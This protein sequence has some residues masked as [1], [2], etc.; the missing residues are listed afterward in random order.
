[1]RSGVEI[2]LEQERAE[3]LQEELQKITQSK[4]IRLDDQTM[5][6]ADI[7]GVFA[8]STMSEHTRRKNGEWQC[9]K[10]VWHKRHEDCG[11][12]EPDTTCNKCFV[13]P[14]VCPTE[15]G[16]NARVGLSRIENKGV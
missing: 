9:Q 15:S 12:R 11:C 7:V 14:C 1:M 16:Q 5:N 6:T 4:F 10:G 8:A 3:R 13:N 2:W